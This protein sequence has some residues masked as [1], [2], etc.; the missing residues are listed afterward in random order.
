[1][2]VAHVPLRKL[3][4]EAVTNRDIHKEFVHEIDFM[5]YVV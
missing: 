5:I 2:P 1:V 3:L 4:S